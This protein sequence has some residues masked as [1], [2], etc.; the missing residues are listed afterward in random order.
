M[1]PETMIEREQRQR[2]QQQQQQ[3]QQQL[4]PPSLKKIR[5]SVVIDEGQN[6]T[7]QQIQPQPVAA[8]SSSFGTSSSSLS[9]TL[10]KEAEE[11]NQRHPS[12]LPPITLTIKGVQQAITALQNAYDTN[13][14]HRMKAQQQ[15]K[16]QQQQHES[17]Q[18]K[19]D[20]S[21]QQ[22][23]ASSTMDV[24][25]Y[26]ESEIR[27]YEAITRLK[28]IA[29]HP[30]LYYPILL[31]QDVFPQLVLPL[32]LHENVDIIISVVSLLLEWLDIDSV[33]N[34][35]EDKEEAEEE[36]KHTHHD[37][38]P[39]SR[40]KT[41]VVIRQVVLELF[42]SGVAD[43]IVDN[44]GR[45]MMITNDEKKG[46]RHDDSNE[47]EEEDDDEV[48]R[49][50]DDVL[51]LFENL[52][53]LDMMNPVTTSTSK[54]SSTT[55]TSSTTLTVTTSVAYNIVAHTN[56]ISCLLYKQQSN[57]DGNNT[58][59]DKILS[60]RYRC[61]ELLMTITTR[62]E[63][64]SIPTVQDWTKLPPF[65]VSNSNNNNNLDHATDTSNTNDHHKSSTSK[66]NTD[67]SA[68][69]YIDGIETLLLIVGQYRKRQPKNVEEMEYIE[70]TC[71]V[72]T[73]ILTY[74]NPNI[75]ITAFIEAQGMELIVRCLK[76]RVYA[77]AT[78]L[79]WLDFS[80]GNTVQSNNTNAAENDQHRR[81]A[82]EHIVQVGLLKY[83]FPLFMGKN[84]PRYC[85]YNTDTGPQ[86][87]KKSKN[88]QL[89]RK[90]EYYNKIETT[91]IR[92]L[93]ALVRHLRDDSPNDVKARFLTKFIDDETKIHRLIDLFLKYDRQVRLAEFKF[94]QSDVEDVILE[95]GNATIDTNENGANKND[96]I[97]QLALL[98]A[99]L[100]AGGDVLYRIAAII[101]FCCRNSKKCHTQI[102]QQL[103]VKQSGMSVIKDA[104]QEFISILDYT[105]NQKAVLELYLEYI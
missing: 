93:Y 73:S 85:D 55:S 87:S 36:E 102:I 23:D 20:T 92:I 40:T 37:T 43:L 71:I 59:Q 42:T 25:V 56:F 9:A 26:M 98:D 89:K 44:I 33:M 27:L 62:D 35:E 4:Q 67:P 22:S 49:G 77:G 1:I 60:Y 103:K 39:D 5:K 83:L 52:L 94:Y 51:S 6:E 63:I 66:T 12:S 75:N 101:A 91:T 97:V 24:T 86:L 18:N 34:D 105:T 88:K 14:R 84:L 100:Q 7:Y 16:Q 96:S 79:S 17:Y 90:Q 99:K 61:M 80:V 70:N 46:G 65:N 31:Q 48:G 50:L 81:N 8:V 58:N 38:N 3:Q 2:Q 11:R 21:G 69:L 28:A 74:S 47:E 76:E 30:K 95:N 78:T 82:C 57:I 104:L 10:L 19:E 64:Y 29:I 32:L 13:G 41:D 15:Q 54:G 53:E 72:L 45:M 68:E